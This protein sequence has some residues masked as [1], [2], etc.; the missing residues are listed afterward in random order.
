MSTI[1]IQN[2]ATINNCIGSHHNGNCKSIIAIDIHKTFNSGLDAATYFGCHAHQIYSALKKPTPSIRMYER[3]EN[4]NRI[5][6]IGTCRLAYA[7]HATE[8]I[9]ALMD[10]G[11]TV[12]NELDKANKKLAEQEA[13]MA[14]F[15]AWK[16]EQEAKRKAEEVRQQKLAKVKDTIE[17]RKRIAIRREA[18]CENAWN[19]VHEAE[20]ELAKLLGEKEDVNANVCAMA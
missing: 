7:A 4:G 5:R 15:R 17:R 11:R 20:M 12:M 16:A 1:T 6:F 8:S 10:H 18:E 3:D 14:E 9:D 13:E 2:K 19:R